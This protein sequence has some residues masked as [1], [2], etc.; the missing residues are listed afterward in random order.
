V[1]ER[2]RK[3]LQ[4]E[5][6]SE[7]DPLPT[8]K[9]SYSHGKAVQTILVGQAVEGGVYDFAPVIN[10]FLRS[11][12]FGD[13]FGR[14]VLDYQSRELA[15]IGALASMEGLETQLRSHLRVS[16]NVGLTESQ[17]YGF[18]E[19]M[20]G[21]VGA[22]EGLRARHALNEILNK[23]GTDIGT[24]ST[25]RSIP[26]Q[27]NVFPKG[28]LYE[29]ETFSGDAWLQWLVSANDGYDCTIGNV[30]FSPGCRNNWHSHTEGQILLC[31]SGKGYYQEKGSPIQLLN[32]GDVVKIA[33]NVVHW[34]GAS[35]S[36]EFTHIAIGPESS[37]NKVTWLSP[38]TDEEY[39]SLICQ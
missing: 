19:A 18:V 15:T 4:D 7:S 14:N 11:H 32:P 6:G 9:S 17:L 20:Q 28:S 8:D 13:I 35:P 10:D 29:S 16:L 22:T 12:L 24:A 5:V 21:R 37:K 1:E 38:V 36:S 30:T 26:Q 33:P 23:V 2:Q 27:K 34:H 25:Q 31:I 3:G 39:N